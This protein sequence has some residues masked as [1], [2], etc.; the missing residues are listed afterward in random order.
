MRV[1]RTHDCHRAAESAETPRPLTPLTPRLDP[2]GAFMENDRRT[3]APVIGA[4]LWSVKETAA[5]L[6]IPVATMY[7]WRHHSCGPPAY[8]VGRHLRYDPADVRRWLTHGAA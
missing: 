5:Y 8:R 3:D 1:S 4:R 2:L 6:G 7:R